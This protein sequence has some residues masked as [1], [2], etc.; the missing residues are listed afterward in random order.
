V[1]SHRRAK[2]HPQHLHLRSAR[3]TPGHDR[4]AHSVDGG[5]AV[6]R[7]VTGHSAAAFFPANCKTDPRKL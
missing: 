5:S 3:P 4:C 7:D 6:E 2:A 1:T